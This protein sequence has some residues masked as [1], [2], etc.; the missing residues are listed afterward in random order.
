MYER[1]GSSSFGRGRPQ[2]TSK[3]RTN[4]TTRVKRSREEV[5]MV[6]KKS[7]RQV[8]TLNMV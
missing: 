3:S 4:S 7:V 6:V 1:D 2:E 8:T 5:V